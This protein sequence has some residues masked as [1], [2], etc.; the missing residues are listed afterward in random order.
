[1]TEPTRRSV[2]VTDFDGTMT[3]RDYY[4]LVNER[5]MPPGAPDYWGRYKAG[6]LTH[7]EALKAIFGEPEAGEAALIELAHA[8]GL[9]PEAAEGVSRLRAAGWEVVVASAGCGWYI[10]ELLGEAGVDVEIH[11]NPGRVEGGRLVMEF[12]EA[13]PFPSREMGVDKAA[14]VRSL[15]DEGR[16]VAYAGDS[17]SDLG[18]ALEVPGDLRFACDELAGALRDRGE[19]F[20]PFGRWIE[21]ARALVGEA[22]R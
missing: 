1:M 10:R 18:P 16:T 15:Q 4:K 14:L 20:R 17:E 5:L 7:F 22:G 12:P 3:E 8:A 9:D 11:A 19:P 13:S 6:Q 2:L 21:V